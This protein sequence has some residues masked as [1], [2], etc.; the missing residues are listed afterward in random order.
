M[1]EEDIK[2]VKIYNKCDWQTSIFTP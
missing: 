2:E 1:S